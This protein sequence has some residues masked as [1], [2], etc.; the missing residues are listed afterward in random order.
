MTPADYPSYPEI[1]WTRELAG[2]RADAIVATTVECQCC[3]HSID[4]L[5]NAE[6]GRFISTSGWVANGTAW[7]CPVC[8]ALLASGKPARLVERPGP[9]EKLNASE[10]AMLRRAGAAA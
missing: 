5:S 10:L 6:K 3:K 9:K 2:A 4:F 1:P 8:V 7:R